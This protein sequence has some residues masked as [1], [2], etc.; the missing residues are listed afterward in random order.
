MFIRAQARFTGRIPKDT[1]KGLIFSLSPSLS[2]VGL[3][4]L[5][6]KVEGTKTNEELLN[7]VLNI[8]VSYLDAIREKAK[9][10]T[11]HKIQQTLIDAARQDA[12]VD[13]DDVLGRE[14]SDLWDDVSNDVSRVIGTETSVARNVSTMDA[15]TKINLSAGISDPTVAFVVVRDEHVCD[16]CQRLHMLPDGIT[17]RVWKLSEVRS[18]YGKPNDLTPTMTRHPHCR[19]SLISV[20]PGYGFSESGMITYKEP[21]WD[22]YRNQRGI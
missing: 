14:L 6:S 20:L 1:P 8:G 18:A 19:C 17:P 10:K 3:Y 4:N 11:V 22:E 2:V 15:I 21:G 7:S 5:A 9:A 16:S 13:I 12:D